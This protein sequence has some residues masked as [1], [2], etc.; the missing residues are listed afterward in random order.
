LLNILAPLRKDNVI[1][2]RGLRSFFSGLIPLFVLA[3]FAHHLLLALPTPLLPFI[4]N[5]FNLSYTQSSLVTSSFNFANGIGQLPAGWLADR[6]GQRILITIGICGVAAAGI[7]VG[8]S[9]GYIILIAFLVLMGLMAGG[10]HPA[11]APLISTSV[12]SNKRGQ[13]L[14][15]HQIGGTASFFMA[16]LIAAAIAATWGW[17]SV[18]I[19]LGIPAMVLGIICFLVLRQ[20][21]KDIKIGKSAPVV[22]DK[23]ALPRGYRRNLVFFL[24]LTIFAWGTANSITPFIPLYLVDHFGVSM[25]TAASLTAISASAGLWA[26]PLGGYV[27]DRTG[28]IPIIL[29]TCLIAGVFVYL[30][31]AVSYGIGVFALLAFIGINQY[32]RMPVAESYI[33]GQTPARRRSTIYGIYYFAQMETGVVFAPLMGLVIDRFGYHVGFTGASII[34]VAVT[35]ICSVFLWGTEKQAS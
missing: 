24:A 18:F 15:L 22:G 13:A 30:W 17:H 7:L 14:G 35:V 11:A 28:R 32:L 21:G 19:A 23:E 20:R 4:R 31:N 34:A 16:P 8:F 9:Y 12:A 1:K 29:G 10:Y 27:S 3:H 33:M 6:I 26:S 25:A 2:A 5:E